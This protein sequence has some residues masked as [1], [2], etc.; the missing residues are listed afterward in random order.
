MEK[1]GRGNR[2][3]PL[4]A[5]WCSP[6]ER[7]EGFYD[8]HFPERTLRPGE[9]RSC[10]QDP[11]K[12]AE[13]LDS[14]AQH[15]SPWTSD[16]EPQLQRGLQLCTQVEVWGSGLKGRCHRARLPPGSAIHSGVGVTLY[17]GLW[18]G[19]DGMR[20]AQ[21][22]LPMSVRFLL[23]TSLVLGGRFTCA[24]VCVCVCH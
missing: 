12:A 2:E 19:E 13:A 8:S 17:I 9:G 24:S 11:L 18:V 6:T 14:E 1:P 7:K 23:P 22:K 21:G 3:S 16:S 5:A 20:W 4:R 15:P 10:A